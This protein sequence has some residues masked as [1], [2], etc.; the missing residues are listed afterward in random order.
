MRRNI[1]LFV[2][3]LLFINLF[4]QNVGSGAVGN[5]SAFTFTGAL[6]E[7]GQLQML[8]Y[9]W[10]HIP[11]PG[12]Y[13]VPD[14]T[15]VLTLIS[16]AGGPTD[17][18]KIRSI[19]IVRSSP[20]SEGEVIFVD[21]KRYIETGDASLIPKLKPGDTVVVS[22]SAYFAFRRFVQFLSNIATALSIW[23]LIQNL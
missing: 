1:V 8:T 22:G 20:D 14:D 13:I 9:I 2:I 23:I 5:V 16:L 17:D 3:L 10:G 19:R 18:A 11:R 7:P 21:L 15:D 4:P 6:N 12:L